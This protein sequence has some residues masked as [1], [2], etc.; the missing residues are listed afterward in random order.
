MIRTPP[1]LAGL[2]RVLTKDGLSDLQ[3]CIDVLMDHRDQCDNLLEFYVGNWWSGFGRREDRED[4]NQSV[5]FTID[6]WKSQQR[7]LV[8]FVNITTLNVVN[9]NEL[10]RKELEEA[11]SIASNTVTLLGHESDKITRYLS[12]LT[13][14]I[15]YLLTL[16]KDLKGLKTRY[17]EE[18]RWKDP[19]ENKSEP[20]K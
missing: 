14:T 9:L 19:G 10:N 12:E 13:T 18:R 15:T 7:N 1:A 17:T 11:W 4:P 16:Q 2:L 20:Q 3:T 6:C 8:P 5:E